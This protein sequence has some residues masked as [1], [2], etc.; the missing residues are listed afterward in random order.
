MAV[1]AW[2]LETQVQEAEA[3]TQVAMEEVVC[4]QPAAVETE[5]DSDAPQI[6]AYPEGSGDEETPGM[7]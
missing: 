4:S 7:G 2:A 5:D 3:E 1:P 6:E